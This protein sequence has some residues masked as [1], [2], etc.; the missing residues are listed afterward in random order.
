MPCV[1]LRDRVV[2][3][4]LAGP[5]LVDRVGRPR[6]WATYLLARSGSHWANSTR[7]RYLRAVERF[8]LFVEAKTGTDCLDELLASLD[9]DRLQQ[10]LEGF[11]GSL[12]NEQSQTGY[13]RANSWSVAKRF[14]QMCVDDLVHQTP[15]GSRR[16]SLLQRLE[17]L[18]TI[19]DQVRT[20][21]R[22]KRQKIRA[23]PASVVE[24][25]YE[26]VWP[27]SGRNPFRSSSVRHRNFVIFLLL[28]HQG[29]RRSEALLLPVNA[30]HGERDAR[31]DAYRYWI[32]IAWNPYEDDDPRTETPS[33]K[34]EWAVRQ[35][36]LAEPLAIAIDNYAQN[37]R[38]RQRHSFLFTS[39]ERQPMSPNGT[40]HAFRILSTC[41]SKAAARELW[42]RRRETWISPHDFRHTCAVFRLRQLVASGIAL[43]EA[44]E[45]LRG[46]FGW[47]PKS[48][49]PR[50]YGRAYFDERLA[51]VWNADFDVRV[52]I[53][54]RLK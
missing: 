17:R 48:D 24:D 16:R 28:L 8:Y 11:L 7:L 34:T 4:G 38:G 53:L 27:D 36:P 23:L 49:M 20:G 1:C 5:V 42:N 39:Q 26:I 51:T 25:L 47:S 3:A 41:L 6:Y 43:E 50:H 12:R 14:V 18:A 45:M 35:I 40:N 31:K 33:L 37:F 15:G 21:R 19:T 22:R 29:L 10:C 30:V 13:S 46:F 52:E 54:R 44:I 2:P 9:I 32:D